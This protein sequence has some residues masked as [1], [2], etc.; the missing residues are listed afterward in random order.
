L[1]FDHIELDR[2]IRP[3]EGSWSWKRSPSEADNGARRDNRLFR[4]AQRV[5]D[6]FARP[7]N[8]RGDYDHGRS[9]A[10]PA[11]IRRRREQVDV[12]RANEAMET[13]IAVEIIP[14]P[15][16]HPLTRLARHQSVRDHRRVAPQG[17]FE[18]RGNAG[19]GLKK[20]G[21]VHCTG[22]EVACVQLAVV[23]KDPISY[24]EHR[25]FSLFF[26]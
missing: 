8:L 9:P 1:L 17:A 22:F 14:G 10:P 16:H 3:F 18:N 25:F 13:Q 12:L 26:F 7:A 20:G 5:L 2:L 19:S 23:Q 11:R 24:P 6:L 4:H 15:K 21:R